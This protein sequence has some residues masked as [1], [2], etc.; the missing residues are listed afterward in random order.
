MKRFLLAV[1][2]LV[3]STFVQAQKVRV[4][5]AANAQFVAQKIAEAFK[6]QT[7]IEAELIVSSSGK[8]TTQIEQGAPFDVFLSAD[9]KYPEE[10]YSKGFGLEKPRI[11]GYGQLVIWTLH[12]D[13]PLK[14]V[15]DLQQKAFQKIAIGNPALAPYGEAAM[16]AI[17]ALRLEATLKDKFVY[18]ESIAQ[19]NQ[20]LLTGAVDAAFTAKSIV[21]DPSLQVR[22]KWIAVPQ[23][24]YLPIA[25]GML[26]I[27]QLDQKNLNNSYK[28]YNFLVSSSAK[29]IFKLYGYK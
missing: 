6:K 27:K 19:V 26:I 25:Q 8:L 5:V 22:G 15:A 16:Q 29:Q 14:Q 9:M 10:L 24:F 13:V 21:L 18:G 4:A 11:Y 1:G 2:L 17:K 3:F 23:R 7:G 20:Y 12:Q 28:F